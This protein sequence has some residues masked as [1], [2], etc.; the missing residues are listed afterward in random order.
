MNWIDNKAKQIIEE[1]VRVNFEPIE[2]VKPGRCRYNFRC[3]DNAAH[4]A[5]RKEQ[6][7]LALTIYISEGTPIIHCINVNE[8]NEFIDNTFGCLCH[9]KEYFFVRYIHKNEIRYRYDLL[10]SMRNE[11]ARQF[12]FYI[13]WLTKYKG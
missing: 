10:E 1:Y 8:N 5:L 7:R 3:F 6:D 12:P 2:N 13:R 4:E 11:F 9:E